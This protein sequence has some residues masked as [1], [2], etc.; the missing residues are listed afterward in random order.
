MSEVKFASREIVKAMKEK[1]GDDVKN[2][3]GKVKY[4]R[5]FQRFIS[6]MDKAHQRTAQS[7]L[8]FS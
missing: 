3:T 1:F 4:S 2:V 7:T 8:H 6:K 5:D